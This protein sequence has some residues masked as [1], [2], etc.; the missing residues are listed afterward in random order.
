[1]FLAKWH[2]ETTD[3][4]CKDIEQFSCTIELE[5]LVDECVEA[6]GD[7]LSD[8]LSSWD[9]LCVEAVK[10][11]L[12]ILTLTWFFGIEQ[13]QEFLNENMCDVHLQ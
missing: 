13:V 1:M 8:H 10:N 12:Q 7:C 5:V 4:T 3:D 11:V 9:E 6:V 2:C